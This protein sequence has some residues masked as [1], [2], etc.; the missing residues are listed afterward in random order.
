MLAGWARGRRSAPHDHGRANGFVVV[1][2]G[3]FSETSYDFDGRDVQPRA[4]RQL[5]VGEV[6]RASPGDI[7]DMRAERDGA[8][9][10]L[11][12]PAIHAMRVYDRRAR[13]TLR[14]SDACG[15]WVPRDLALVLERTL[16]AA[17][18]TS[19]SHE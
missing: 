15:A 4:K 14:V 19:A 1:L 13:V 11:Y 6:L 9:L 18:T 16:W 10:H 12:W 7:H 17:A 8:T 2:A 3:A 5:A